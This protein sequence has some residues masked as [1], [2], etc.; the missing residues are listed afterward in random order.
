MKLTTVLVCIHLLCWIASYSSLIIV[1]HYFILFSLFFFVFFAGSEV[2]ICV[3]VAKTMGDGGVRVRVVSMPC[4]ELFEAQD[5]AYQLTGEQS[6]CC[7]AVHP[8][9][10]NSSNA[11]VP[12]TYHQDNSRPTMGGVTF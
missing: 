11:I 3:D 10:I 12:S 1:Y 4:W 8:V 2:Q 7:A 9:S 6:S 5:M